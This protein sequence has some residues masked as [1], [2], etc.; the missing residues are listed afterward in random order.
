MWARLNNATD[1]VTYHATW[2]EAMGL[3]PVPDPELIEP[4]S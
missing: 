1:D 2:E 4:C 3:A